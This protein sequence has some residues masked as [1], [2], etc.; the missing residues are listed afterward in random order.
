[1][2][3]FFATKVTTELVILSIYNQFRVATQ[4]WIKL[5]YVMLVIYIYFFF[6]FIQQP[7]IIYTK[8]NLQ[9]E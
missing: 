2:D 9:L 8:V 4:L 3:H 1:M 5:V 7:I 6:I